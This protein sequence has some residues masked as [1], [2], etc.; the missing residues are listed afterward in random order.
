M[1][2]EVWKP[3]VGYEGLYEVSGKQQADI[4]G[5]TQKN[6]AAFHPAAPAVR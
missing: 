6:R 4:Y 5:V 3:V 1:E 2:N